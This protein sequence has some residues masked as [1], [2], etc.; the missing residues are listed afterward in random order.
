MTD[1]I[2][3]LEAQHKQ[4]LT[5]RTA[6]DLLETRKTLQQT[7]DVTT[8]RFL[9]LR[10]K[11]YY[12]YGDKTGKFLVRALKG[13][14]NKNN[15][16]CIKNKDGT[17]DITD[18]LIARQFH[19]Y[20]TNL[21]NFLKQHKPADVQGSRIQIIQEYLNSYCEQGTTVGVKGLITN[22]LLYFVIYYICS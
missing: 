8:K 20:Y 14:W 19:D 4:S 13:P 18:E 22:G 9:F 21:Y 12:E 3:K 16:L 11:I 5:T 17:L 2:L 1:K 10:K 15:I 7:L 6:N